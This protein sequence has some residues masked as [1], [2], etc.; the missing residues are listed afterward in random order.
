LGGL[1]TTF[2]ALD[3]VSQGQGVFEGLQAI[4]DAA[5]DR[6]EMILDKK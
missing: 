4:Y 3:T 2:L 5:P 6:F 1:V